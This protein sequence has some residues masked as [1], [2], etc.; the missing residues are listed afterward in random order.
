VAGGVGVADDG[1]EGEA[2]GVTV[3]RDKVAVAGIDVCVA[4]RDGSGAMVDRGAAVRVGVGAGA[5][6]PETDTVI[7]SPRAAQLSQRILLLYL[8]LA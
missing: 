6:Q 5:A 3:G 4:V 8:C 2:V 7:A 1:D